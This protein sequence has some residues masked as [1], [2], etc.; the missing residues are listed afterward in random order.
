MFSLFESSTLSICYL[1]CH[2]NNIRI[3]L[4]CIVLYCIVLYFFVLYCIVFSSIVIRAED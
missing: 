2:L 4:Y 3:V 1:L